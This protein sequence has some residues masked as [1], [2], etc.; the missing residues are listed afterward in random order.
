MDGAWHFTIAPNMWF[1][2]ISG[3]ISVAN[4]AEIPVEVSL[5]DMIEDVDVSLGW[6]HME[7][8]C[9]KGEGLDRRLRDRARR[10]Q[11]VVRR[12]VV[13][14]MS[15]RASALSA[16]QAAARAAGKRRTRRPSPR[17]E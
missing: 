1:S 5:S 3:D 15:V 8:D 11:A 7:I 4:L 12:R 6:R 2:G 13:G 10:P 16:P 14:A 9:D 17:G